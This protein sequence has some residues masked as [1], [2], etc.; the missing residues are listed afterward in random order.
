[1]R[2]DARRLKLLPIHLHT[3][4]RTVAHMQTHL[5]KNLFHGDGL[6]LRFPETVLNFDGAFYGM[7]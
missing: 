6:F 3:Y 1:M 7:L 4:A 5:G 2:D